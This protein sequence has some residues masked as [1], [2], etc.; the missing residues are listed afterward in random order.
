MEQLEVNSEEQEDFVDFIIPAEREG[1]IEE[2]KQR[3]EQRRPRKKKGKRTTN[4]NGEESEGPL[5]REGHD[6]SDRKKG[7][8]NR[9]TLI[10]RLS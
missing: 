10:N 2:R 5:E 7:K 6:A 3:K 9:R 1:V 4:I 8:Q